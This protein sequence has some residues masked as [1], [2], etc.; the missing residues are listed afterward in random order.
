MLSAWVLKK[1]FTHFENNF[2]GHP[3]IE[4]TRE[5]SY[6]AVIIAMGYLA[7]VY[8]GPKC[9]KNRPAM[10]V[11]PLLAAW[12]LILCLFSI[13]GASH[14]VPKLVFAL[15][16]PARGLTYT[17]C[18]D[19]QKW[20]MDGAAGCWL[21]LFV[22]SKIP[23]LTDTVFLVV[24][25]KPVI[26]LHWYHHCSVLLYCWHAY[27]TSAAPGIWFAAMNFLVHSAMY[28]YY[29]ATN[30]GLFKYVRPIAP[31]ITT[32]QISQMIAGT[33]IMIKCAWE[34]YNAVTSFGKPC[35]IE[36]SNLLFG[37]GMYLSYFLLFALFFVGKYCSRKGGGLK[38]ASQNYNKKA[39]IVAVAVVAAAAA[40]AFST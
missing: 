10:H 14:L 27:Q 23:E 34:K 22:F 24:R 28:G 15:M 25:K 37:L 1:Q 33:A 40:A 18:A 7:F 21:A 12:N 38:P 32:L 26:F 5:Y 30:I 9:M 19:P 13:L 4:W 36:E 11:K 35:H 31:I 16:D 20:V 29:L 3:I 39:S 2:K 8:A 6:V 17:M